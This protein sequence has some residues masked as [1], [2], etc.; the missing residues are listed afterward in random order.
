MVRGMSEEIFG[1]VDYGVLS[2][3]VAT[4]KLAPEPKD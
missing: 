2:V 3:R 4:A 1:V